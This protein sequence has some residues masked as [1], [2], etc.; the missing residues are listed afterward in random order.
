MEYLGIGIA[1]A[2][3]S[4]SASSVIITVLKVKMQKANNIQEGSAGCP[5]HSGMEATLTFVKDAI[6]IIQEDIKKLLAR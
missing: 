2:G 6:E 5:L 1:I 3:V 4:I